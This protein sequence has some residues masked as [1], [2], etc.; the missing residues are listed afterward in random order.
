VANTSTLVWTSE[1]NAPVQ[2]YL[3]VEDPRCELDDPEGGVCLTPLNRDGT[4]SRH[5]DVPAVRV[6][7]DWC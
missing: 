4:C 3:P 2:E 7:P 5:D 1:A 6:Y